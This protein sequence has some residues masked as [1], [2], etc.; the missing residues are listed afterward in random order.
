ESGIPLL[1]Q[2]VDAMDTGTLVDIFRA[3][4]NTC[5]LGTDAVRD[6]V[7]VPGRSLRLIVFDRVPWPRPDILHRARKQNFGKGYDDMI[8][9]LRLKQ[10]YG[11][12]LRRAEDKGVFV[13]LDGMLPTRLTTA[14]PDGVEIQRLGLAEAIEQTREFLRE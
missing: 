10:A 12:L 1:A 3:E 4:E 6:G 11:R 7:D 14:F 13:M 9:R 2:H 5:L 8:A